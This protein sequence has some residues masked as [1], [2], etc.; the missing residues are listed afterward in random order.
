MKKFLCVFISFIIVLSLTPSRVIASNSVLVKA[1]NIL[2]VPTDKVVNFSVDISNLSSSVNFELLDKDE[3]IPIQVTKRTSN[4]VQLKALLHF[5]SL[6]DKKLTLRYGKDIAPDYTFIFK[7]NFS[8]TY[9]IGIGSG[10]LY[11]ASLHEKNN[12]NIK[13]GKGKVIFKGEL[14]TNETKS[15]HLYSKDKIFSIHSSYPIVAEVSSLKKDCISSS[16]DDVSSVYGSYFI[17]FIPKEIFISTYKDTHLKLYSISG[18]KIFDG[19]IPERSLYKN[20]SLKPN[21][22]VVTSDNPVTIQF[23]YADDNIYFVGYGSANAFKGVS[24]GNIVCSSLFSDTDVAVKTASKQYPLNKLAKT[25]DFLYESNIKKFSPSSTE[26]TPIYITYTKPVLIYSDMNAG[27]IGG[28]QIPSVDGKGLHFVFRTG[29][30]YNFSGTTHKRNVVIIA[31][32]NDTHITVNG[33]KITINALKSYVTNSTES[34]QLVNISSDK[35]VSVFDVGINTSLEFLS[36]LLPLEDNSITPVKVIASVSSNGLFGPDSS[37]G[38]FLSP[39]FLF[40]KSFWGNITNTNWY[41]NVSDTLKE[42]YR[43][44]FPSIKNFSRRIIGFF[45]PAA[46]LIY[47][48]IHNYLPGI[49]KYELASIIFYILLA[50]IILLLLIPKRRKKRPLPTVG[51]REAKKKMPTFNVKILEEKGPAGFKYE[52]KATS[53]SIPIPAKIVKEKPGSKFETGKVPH[54]TIKPVK[55]T[56]TIFVTPKKREKTIGQKSESG[57]IKPVSEVLKEAKKTI[58]A[59]PKKEVVGKEKEISVQLKKAT[60]AEKTGATKGA[61]TKKTPI[62]PKAGEKKPQKPLKKPERKEK[63]VEEVNLHLRFCLRE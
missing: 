28:E 26:Y 31:S 61:L 22:Y 49:D 42:F 34:Y 7:P 40:L 10:M 45:L 20:L 30:I 21:F 23:G 53:K 62:L 60:K 33:K 19:N 46:E 56:K 1:K 39:V 37:I 17:L 36:I 18:I 5:S 63:A 38:H 58:P 3:K 43:V 59:L 41:I 16:S 12:I 13:D 44:V 6:E 35:P 51:L 9:F 54:R 52:A 57:V 48:Y 32:E 27:N 55:A 8:G 29:R 14:G 47:P 50:L 4:N 11:I 2:D 15:I 25:G 24:F